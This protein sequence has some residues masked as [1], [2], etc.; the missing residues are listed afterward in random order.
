MPLSGEVSRTHGEDVNPFDVPWRSNVCREKSADAMV[1]QER[2]PMGKGWIGQCKSKW[3]LPC[4]SFVVRC[5]KGTIYSHD[6]TESDNSIEVTL[7]KGKAKKQLA[8]HREMRKSETAV[9]RTAR[10]VVWEVGKCESRRKRLL[11]L[12]ITSY[13]IVTFCL[14]IDSKF[15][16]PKVQVKSR[17]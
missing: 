10:A 4:D 5:P 6:R 12:A 2:V 11:W 15:H 3:M 8:T 1:P 9:C 16:A 13:S 7:V 14:S 17:Q